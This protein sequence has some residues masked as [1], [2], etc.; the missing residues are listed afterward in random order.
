MFCG[1]SAPPPPSSSQCFLIWLYLQVQICAHVHVYL[2]LSL[3]CVFLPFFVYVQAGCEFVRILTPLMSVCVRMCL[4]VFITLI[5]ACVFIH[6]LSVMKW[7]SELASGEES[8]L[9][10]FIICV[11]G[12]LHIYCRK[13]TISQTVAER[14]WKTPNIFA[15]RCKRKRAVFIFFSLPSLWTFA[16][17]TLKSILYLL[18]YKSFLWTQR[19]LFICVCLCRISDVGT[20]LYHWFSATLIAALLN[21][22]RITKGIWR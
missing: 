9:L 16:P 13:A 12:L 5:N 7:E 15:E 3:C 21:A 8:Y 19:V 10:G 2:H 4:R 6:P 18:G 14:A 17:T 20:F 11:P 22:E 1:P